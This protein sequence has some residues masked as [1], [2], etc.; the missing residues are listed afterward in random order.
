MV[1]L[2]LVAFVG[3]A[4]SALTPCVLPILPA[5][6]AVSAGEGRRRVWGIVLGLELSFFLIGIVLAASLSAIGLPSNILQWLAA[7]LLVAFAAT[8][9]V[10]SLHAR[11]QTFVSRLTAPVAG[12]VSTRSGFVGGLLAGAPLGLI[13]APCAG[14]ILAGITVAGASMRFSGRTVVMM[15][16][17][18]L[19]ML[20]PLLAIGFGGHRASQWLKR[21]VGS[22]RRLELGMGTI[23]L[24]TAAMVGFGWANTI[25]RWL[26][27]SVNLTSTPTAALEQQALALGGAHTAREGAR[28][29][30][31]ESELVASG[32]PELEVL[33]DYGR[34]PELKGI[35]HWFNS[36]PATM[37]ELRGKVV[38]IDFWTYSC[39]NCIR[40]LPYLKQWYA[41]YKDEGFVILGVHTPEFNFEKDPNNV[42]QAID[43]FGIEYPVA[44]DP[45]YETWDQYYNRYW[46]AHYLID[47]DGILR[48]VHYGEGAYDRTENE[49]RLLLSLPAMEA[50]AAEEEVG[51]SPRTP[52]TYLGYYRADRFAGETEDAFGLVRDE[53]AYYR[54][55]PV[56]ELPLDWWSYVG[57]WEVHG[58][59]ATSLED[60]AVISL[61][62]RARDVHIVAGPG[63]SGTG[64]LRISDGRN[65]E[66]MEIDDERLY[67]VRSDTYTDDVLRLEFSAGVEVYSFT[68]G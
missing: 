6:L 59:A 7:G 58:Q 23:L 5:L 8:L 66:T 26:A 30:L 38:L 17:Y 65:V 51:V 41:D 55:P 11:W 37:R 33:V 18:A 49:I 20:G 42:A 25:N 19:G 16:A 12:S 32:Y 3:G 1:Y 13:W 2:I 28:V 68:F 35:S 21:K 53:P 36:N 44:L 46:P 63:D 31:S 45:E 9:L 61:H 10:P 27:E 15:V 57:R 47:R 62:F 67:T 22:G 54:A 56:A 52:E 50:G 39:I 34:A 64:T 43:D 40:T 4:V 14:P 29:R 48:S 24:L 60:G